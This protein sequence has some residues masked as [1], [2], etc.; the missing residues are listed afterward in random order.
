MYQKVGMITLPMG[1]DVSSNK[2]IVIW[3]FSS[4]VCQL[5]LTRYDVKEDEDIMLS[6]SIDFDI[7][8]SRGTTAYR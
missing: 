3:N 5:F 7:C 8:T 1:C 6:S 4:A 2:K